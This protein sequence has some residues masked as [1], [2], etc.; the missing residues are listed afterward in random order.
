[1]SEWIKK[2]AVLSTIEAMFGY[3][4]TYDIIDYKELMLEAVKVLPS[5]DR[6]QMSETTISY[7]D[8]AE[9]LLKLWCDNIITDGE[10]NRIMG[11]LNE[12]EGERHEV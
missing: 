10:Y 4:T 8:C 5:A 6:P 11:R 12:S 3:C 2:D 1:M 7:K 9:V